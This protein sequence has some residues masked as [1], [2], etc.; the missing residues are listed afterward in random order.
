M[1]EGDLVLDY[2]PSTEE[3]FGYVARRPGL[4]LD[5]IREPDH[6]SSPGPS[7]EPGHE[8]GA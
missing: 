2:D 8:A 3:G 4:D 1:A 7:P 5:L 6:E